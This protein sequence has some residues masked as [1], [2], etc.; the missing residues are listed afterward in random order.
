M[1]KRKVFLIHEVGIVGAIVAAVLRLMGQD[2]RYLKL[3]RYLS[4]D[5]T[6]EFLA[7]FGI[8][9][10]TYEG[11]GNPGGK[12]FHR[13][14][15]A[16]S[17]LYSEY[18]SN[19]AVERVIANE[20]RMTVSDQERFSRACEHY[21]L[22]EV[23]ELCELL[24]HAEEILTTIRDTQIV[25]LMASTWYARRL[26]AEERR[27]GK[28]VR[29]IVL[30]ALLWLDYAA[31]GWRKYTEAIVNTAKK[32]SRS[33]PTETTAG[34]VIGLSQEVLYF[35]HKGIH[36]SNLYVKDHYY[37]TDPQNPFFA[38]NIL[39]LS[40]GDGDEYRIPNERFYRENGYP[41][42]DLNGLASVSLRHLILSFLHLVW[43]N[44][45]DIFGDSRQGK[46]V[47]IA[48]YFAR[49][50]HLQIILGALRKIPQAKLALVG[51][52]I[53]FP[54]MLSVGLSL[55]GIKTIA[56]QERFFAVFQRVYRLLFDYYFTCGPRICRFL[57]EESRLCLIGRCEPIGPVRAEDILRHSRP[58]PAKYEAIK[59]RY[60]LIL[61]L[62][63]HSMPSAIENARAMSNNWE[64]AKR[65]YVDM[66]RLAVDYPEAYVVIKS[67]DTTATTLPTMHD[68]MRIIKIMPNIEFEVNNDEFSPSLMAAM[69]DFAVGCHTSLLDEVMAIG[70][71]AITYD[72]VGHPTGYFDYD[73]YPMIVTTYDELRSKVAK[74]LRGDSLMDPI[75]FAAMRRD[76]Y[77]VDDCG[78]SPRARLHTRLDA[79]YQDV[80]KNWHPMETEACNG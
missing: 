17:L 19:S 50:C 28:S 27:K 78:I 30:P 10:L 40:L 29:A 72:F 54:P 59:D 80:S 33:G 65:F 61:A 42:A 31:R 55:R 15:A 11:I 9:A 36:Y 7:Q 66:I 23:G 69:A 44:R 63:F 39:H 4:S 35:P 5:R 73:D 3:K 32:D 14:S 20:F 37:S 71:P 21:V 70:K 67:K 34:S 16:S 58:F 26:I 45:K 24:L 46:L 12:F 6:A 64:T 60:R 43:R 8:Q 62:D 13:V 53:L 25:I 57:E 18:F 68:I 38:R 52:D 22:S 51:Y 49:Y 75:Q 1:S 79:I 74:V 2:V 77:S 47:R 48:F 76:Y 56:V 41:Y